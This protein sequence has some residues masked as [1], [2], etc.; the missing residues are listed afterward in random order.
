VNRREFIK[1]VIAINAA[2]AASYCGVKGDGKTK[3]VI[4]GFDGAN[5]P[6]ID[7]LI[8]RGKLPYLQKFRE[9]SAWANFKTQK[10]AKSNVVWTSIAS[11]KT[12]MKHGIMDFVYLKRNGVKVP[13]S[14]SKRK[15]PMIW[16]ILDSYKKR[17]VVINWWVS[18]PPD[19]INGVMVSDGFRRVASSS[20]EKIPNYARTVYPEKYFEKLASFAK[21][22]ND[23]DKV[24][25]R[26]GLLDCIDAFQKNYPQGNFKNIPVL[27]HYHQFVKHDAMVESISD[28]LY[29]N[30]KFDFFATYFRFPDIV[31]HVVTHLMDKKFKGELKEAFK[32]GNVPQDLLNE[33]ILRISAILEP[34][35]LYMESIIK[36]YVTHK[37]QEN[38]YFFIMSDHGFSLYPGGFNHY[39]LPENY[40]APDGFLMINGPDVKKGRIENAGIYD[41]TPTILNL[42]G[43]PVG[44][45]MDGRVLRE[46][47]TSSR[48]IKYKS[49]KLK[50]EGDIEGDK[51]YDK[52]TM[53]ELKSIGYIQ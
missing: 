45:N 37:P 24:L 15:E 50:K 48:S 18:H 27:T 17:S 10:P 36:K 47:F 21:E 49:Y 28:Y 52:E 22:N 20:P 5:W 43:L 44:K 11:G 26:T 46:A 23:Y 32:K 40:P 34:I 38:V 14:K 42:F 39:N 1:N 41:I 35:Y 7:P 12:M 29:T 30:T 9:Q 51:E 19:K 8:K 33:S 3:V 16:Q 53:E 25:E 2:L 13:F 4:L 31:Q 6:T